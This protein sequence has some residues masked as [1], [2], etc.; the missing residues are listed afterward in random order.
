MLFHCYP[1]R[2]CLIISQLTR[3]TAWQRVLQFFWD[4]TNGL[5]FLLSLKNLI[6]GNFVYLKMVNLNWQ[7]KQ[8]LQVVKNCT[9]IFPSKLEVLC[10]TCILLGA[11]CLKNFGRKAI[12]TLARAMICNNFESLHSQ[13]THTHTPILY[14][15]HHNLNL[16]TYQKHVCVTRTVY[17]YIYYDIFYIQSICVVHM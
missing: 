17:I 11:R 14:N 2:I 6:S 5:K 1:C 16:L 13:H 4:T 7:N 8:L 9:K 12:Y 15:L 3:K 10:E